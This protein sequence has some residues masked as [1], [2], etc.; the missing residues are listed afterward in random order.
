MITEDRL[1][2]LEFDARDSFPM[3]SELKEL[4]NAYRMCQHAPKPCPDPSPFIPLSD[5]IALKK[6]LDL[7]ED[8]TRNL[9]NVLV[10]LMNIENYETRKKI[11]NDALRWGSDET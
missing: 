8:R 4:I 6:K 11:I 2:E 10:Q 9:C 1:K 3:R 7:E 5:F